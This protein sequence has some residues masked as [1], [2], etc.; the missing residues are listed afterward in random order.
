M[1]DRLTSDMAVE[2]SVPPNPMMFQSKLAS[3]TIEGNTAHMR[4]SMDANDVQ[5]RFS[6]IVAGPFGPSLAAMIDARRIFRLLLKLVAVQ[7]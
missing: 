1:R 6:Q 2:F 4:L 5:Q 3:A 7:V